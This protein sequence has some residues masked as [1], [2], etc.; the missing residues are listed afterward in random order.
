MP[1]RPT[2]SLATFEYPGGAPLLDRRV[3]PAR[4]QPGRF[5]RLYGVD[6]RF[7]GALRRFPGFKSHLDLRASPYDGD[8]YTGDY[9]NLP[10]INNTGLTEIWF[11]KYLTVRTIF[12]EV[13]IRWPDLNLTN[14]Q[15]S[16]RTLRGFV[17]AH[18]QPDDSNRG[19]LRYYYY[20]P[21]VSAWVY[22]DLLREVAAY[23]TL[24]ND[25]LWPY[26]G[27]LTT[28][29]DLITQDSHYDVCALGP[30][31]Y[32]CIGKASG[33]VSLVGN[34]EEV[35]RSVYLQGI[36]VGEQS[37]DPG[38]KYSMW[39]PTQFGPPAGISHESN[40]FRGGSDSDIQ[41]SIQVV[42]R[43]Y[44]KAKNLY[45]PSTAGL[46]L[47]TGTAPKSWNLSVLLR[48]GKK[49]NFRAANYRALQLG[50]RTYRTL[51]SNLFNE[52]LGTTLPA[53]GTFFQ[54]DDDDLANRVHGLEEDGN[55]NYT[56]SDE[57]VVI[58]DSPDAEV[59]NARS[60]DPLDDDMAFSP[61]ALRLLLPY[62]GTLLRVG[63]SPLPGAFETVAQVD[64]DNVLSWGSLKAFSPEQSRVQDSTPLGHGQDERILA[65]VSGGDYAFALGDSGVFRIH[66]NGVLL[67]IN[68]LQT[69]AG[70]VGRY[71]CLSWGAT[72][73]Y[74]SP[75]GMYAVDGPTGDVELISS[76]DRI[77][78]TE[79]RT[80]LAS[81]RMAYDVGLGALIILN[82]DLDD[83]IVM[84]T[85]TGAVTQLK[86][87]PFKF[88]TQGIHPSANDELLSYW[89]TNKGVIYT[90]NSDRES[91]VAQTMC[92][93]ST[94]LTWNGTA[95]GGS[96]TTLVCSTAT[97]S[98]S[99]QTSFKLYIHSGSNAGLSRTITGISGTT[100]TCDAFPVALASGVR[101]SVAPI[102][103]EVVGHPLT[104]PMDSEIVFHRKIVRQMASNLNLVGGDTDSSTNPNIKMRSALYWRGDLSQTSGGTWLEGS[105]SADSTKNFVYLNRAGTI[106]HPAWSQ[107]ASNL[108]FDWLGGLVHGEVCVSESESDPASA[109][110]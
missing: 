92:G 88:G 36:G 61:Q 89:I 22:H 99:V 4:V 20:D 65:L 71:A 90:P 47:S 94:S 105:M 24:T 110:S 86:D 82:E 35:V 106:L 79:W 101:F 96:T 78:L 81:I 14:A 16:P 59:V 55:N 6:G 23:P 95:T 1:E 13:G 64:R 42:T 68:E 52:G 41:D 104:S 26:R 66:R 107:I 93:G 63:R 72:L 57:T 10:A 5:P 83:A 21:L 29:A 54:E 109:Y 49:N 38:P 33:A 62:Q 103:F 19:V 75:T 46:L 70:G 17:V 67:A 15:L 2:D 30:F 98:D 25:P 100:I 51:D 48:S 27:F 102:Y 97:F 44:I 56:A 7:L 18:P 84:W 37:E 12:P 45:G 87:V 108:D 80:T 58:G 85:S 32:Y 31:L 91:G 60:I 77:L 43:S 39:A 69:L 73:Y 76:M 34:N 53:G 11:F 9:A 50:I 74:I 28:S 40:T 3:H 8:A